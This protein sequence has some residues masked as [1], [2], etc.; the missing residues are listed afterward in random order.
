MSL[1]YIVDVDPSPGERHWMNKLVHYEYYESWHVALHVFH[2]YPSSEGLEGATLW[3]YHYTMPEALDAAFLW[4]TYPKSIARACGLCNRALG[5]PKCVPFNDN[6][7]DTSWPIGMINGVLSLWEF[8]DSGET[9]RYNDMLEQF[10][11]NSP[12]F[13]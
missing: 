13:L 5:H 7:S 2:A 8:Y 4:Y 3:S 9:G 10:Y 6:S 1:K 11:K 12:Q